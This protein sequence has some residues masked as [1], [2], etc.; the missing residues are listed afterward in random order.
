MQY[1]TPGCCPLS[2]LKLS[3]VYRPLSRFPDLYFFHAATLDDP[4][5]FKPRRA[6]WYSR[7]LP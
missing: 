7:A 5:Q 6:V 4:A 1:N 2:A 3:V